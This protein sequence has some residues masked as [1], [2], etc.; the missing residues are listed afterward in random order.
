MA[1]P[2]LVVRGHAGGLLADLV[3]DPALEGAAVAGRRVGRQ[4]LLAD[5]DHVDFFLGI[6]RRLD[7]EL[8]EVVALLGQRVTVITNVRSLVFI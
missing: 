3:R 8:V 2:V 5:R 4:V 7:A 1:P 6:G